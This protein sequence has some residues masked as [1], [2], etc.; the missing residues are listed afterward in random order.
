[1]HEIVRTGGFNLLLLFFDHPKCTDF[2][3]GI[4]EV[5][6]SWQLLLSG[7]II[8]HDEVRTKSLHNPPRRSKRCRNDRRLSV[9]AVCNKSTNL[10]VVAINSFSLRFRGS[11]GCLAFM[12]IKVVHGECEGICAGH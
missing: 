12:N 1:L 5:V 10:I 3:R 2:H 6:C 11:W 9:E 4:D 8:E 7:H